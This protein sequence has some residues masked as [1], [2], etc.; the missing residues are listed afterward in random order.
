MERFT[1]TGTLK[2]KNDND[3]T[4]T[5]S[6]SGYVGSTDFEIAIMKGGVEVANFSGSLA[7]PIRVKH[8]VSG[9]GI[10]MRT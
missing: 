8:Q 1:S 10:W 5:I 9:T 6:F 4:G 7:N 2:Y 3:L